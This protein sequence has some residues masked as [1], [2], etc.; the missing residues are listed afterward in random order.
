VAQHHT[1]QEIVRRAR[2]RLQLGTFKSWQL[3]GKLRIGKPKAD[4]INDPLMPSRLIGLRDLIQ[5]RH[6]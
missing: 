2:Q 5:T 6:A 4:L 3:A 1:G